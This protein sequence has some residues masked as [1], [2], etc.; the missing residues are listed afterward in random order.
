MKATFDGAEHEFRIDRKYVPYLESSLGRS[1]YDCLK[2][3]TDGRWTFSDIAKVVS[4]AMHGPSRED[5]F[6]ISSTLQA[7]RLGMPTHAVGSETPHFVRSYVAHPGVIAVLERD[8]HG[9]YAD[10]AANILTVTIFGDDALEAASDE[11][12]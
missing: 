10:L 7:L 5:R 8:G 4:F 9:N 1:M 12:A 2:S 6:V 11:A 3:F